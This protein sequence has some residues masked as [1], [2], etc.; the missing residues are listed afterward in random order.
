MRIFVPPT[1]GEVMYQ[2]RMS[3]AGW[4]FGKQRS[5]ND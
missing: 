5:N 2:Y 1:W 3:K 4:D